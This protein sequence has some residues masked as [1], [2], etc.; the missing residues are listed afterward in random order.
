M[1]NAPDYWPSGTNAIA[2]SYHANNTAYPYDTFYPSNAIDLNDTTKWNDGTFGEFPD[3]LLITPS[4][5]LDLTGIIVVS[6]QDGWITEFGVRVSDDPSMRNNMIDVP[7]IANVTGIASITTTFTFPETRR[8]AL[9]QVEVFASRDNDY[10]RIHEVYPI[11][12]QSSSSASTAT[13]TMSSS[14]ST[15]ISSPTRASAAPASSTSPPPSSS[16]GGGGTNTGAIAGGVVGG[17]AALLII[18]L[19]FW[20]VRRRKNK[21]QQPAAPT[22]LSGDDYRPELEHKPI[23][24]MNGS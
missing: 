21:Q 24:E 9:V 16:D 11:L 12:A 4:T 17:V 23:H 15:A 8:C 13:S 5:L 7:I 20:L 22:E 14:T 18:I 2:S 6:G 10:S 3:A 19:A 1:A